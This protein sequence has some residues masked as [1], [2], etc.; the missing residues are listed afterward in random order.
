MARGRAF[1]R[2]KARA[3]KDQ[4]R[5]LGKHWGQPDSNTGDPR[6]VGWVASCHGRPKS[7]AC[8]SK[9]EDKDR[10]ELAADLDAR[11]AAG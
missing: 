7:T 5:W 11:G 9:P 10:Q 1:R 4:A 8:C 2:G 6:W 3:R